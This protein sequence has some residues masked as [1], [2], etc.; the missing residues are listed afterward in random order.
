MAS[1]QTLAIIM[2]FNN[3][4]AIIDSHC[5]IMFQYLFTLCYD[6]VQIGQGLNC[7]LYKLAIG[8]VHLVYSH[9][10]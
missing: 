6:L 3:R 5:I 1:D 8:K 4:I 9:S 2:K 7:D 10:I